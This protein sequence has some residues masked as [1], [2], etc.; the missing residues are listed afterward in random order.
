MML[1]SLSLSAW[2]RSVTPGVSFPVV[3]ARA[4]PSNISLASVGPINRYSIIAVVN[5][6][7]NSVSARPMFSFVT[8][9]S[10]SV[11]PVVYTAATPNVSCQN[12][13]FRQRTIGAAA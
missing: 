5:R 6:I 13:D 3:S 10:E 1:R 9:V 11:I 2:Y 4:M 8:G 12:I 7:A